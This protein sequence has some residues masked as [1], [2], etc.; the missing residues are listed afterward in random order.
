MLN[1]K[2]YLKAIT[3]PLGHNVWMLGSIEY[4]WRSLSCY[5]A[6]PWAS[7]RPPS[8]FP[9]PIPALLFCSYLG[10]PSGSTFLGLLDHRVIP[11]PRPCLVYYHLLFFLF[12]PSLIHLTSCTLLT[13]SSV[14]Y[15]SLSYSS[16]FAYR[17]TLCPGYYWLVTLISCTI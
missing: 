10:S 3:S 8:L 4:S 6:C 11:M 2:Y 1:L 5:A 16:L 7:A 12:P 15:S 14:P 9:H 17:L 13:L